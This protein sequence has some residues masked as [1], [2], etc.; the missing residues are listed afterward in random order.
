[1]H[2]LMDTA[3]VCPCVLDLLVLPNLKLSSNQTLLS[4]DSAPACCCLLPIIAV[5]S[6]IVTYRLHWN[7]CL[8]FKGSDPIDKA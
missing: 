1:M 4:S 5:L 3:H 7:V 6:R 8:G 2:S